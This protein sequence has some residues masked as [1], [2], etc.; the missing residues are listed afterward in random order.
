MAPVF[1]GWQTQQRGCLNFPYPELDE[2]DP[3]AL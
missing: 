3:E 1:P 2:K